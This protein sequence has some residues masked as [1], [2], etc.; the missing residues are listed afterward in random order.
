V[1]YRLL[2]GPKGVVHLQLLVGLD[3]GC[4]GG[5]EQWEVDVRREG[6]HHQEHSLVSRR[7]ATSR[8]GDGRTTEMRVGGTADRAHNLAFDVP[9]FIFLYACC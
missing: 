6:A 9:L 1:A 3:C 8:S 2:R 4:A 7:L 5:A